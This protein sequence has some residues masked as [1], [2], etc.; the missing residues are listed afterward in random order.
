MSEYLTA[1]NVPHESCVELDGPYVLDIVLPD[2]TVLMLTS[3]VTADSGEACGLAWLQVI[4]LFE[5]ETV[6]NSFKIFLWGSNDYPNVGRGNNKN[7]GCGFFCSDVDRNKEYEYFNNSNREYF[8]NFATFTPPCLN[9]STSK[10]T[11][12][13]LEMQKHFKGGFCMFGSEYQF[14]PC[15]QPKAPILCR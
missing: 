3:E 15:F 1:L 2:R 4:F 14:L 9:E 8:E 12:S 13:T 6:S 11:K 10:H 7:P 5:K